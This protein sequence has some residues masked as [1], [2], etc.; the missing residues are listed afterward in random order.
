MYPA[1]NADVPPAVTPGAGM[2]PL[3]DTFPAAED[4]PYGAANLFGSIKPTGPGGVPATGSAD[5]RSSTFAPAMDDPG[6]KAPPDVAVPDSRS[7]TTKADGY[8]VDTFRGHA[9]QQES[10]SGYPQTPDVYSAYGNRAFVPSGPGYPTYYPAPQAAYPP[11]STAGAPT[12]RNPADSPAT[13]YGYP[14]TAPEPTPLPQVQPMQAYQA[15]P[16]T[17]SSATAPAETPGDYFRPTD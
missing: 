2:L 10:F 13:P 6:H 5:P 1:R 3:P 16:G 14:G 8:P 12:W 11:S 17:G 7:A 15:T 4:E 9:P